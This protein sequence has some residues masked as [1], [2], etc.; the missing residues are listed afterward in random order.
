VL[1]PAIL[2]VVLLAGCFVGLAPE[3]SHPVTT[4]EGV[5]FTKSAPKV[6]RTSIEESTAEL[7]IIGEAQTSNGAKNRATTVS[8]QRERWREEVLAVFDRIVTK[9]RITYELI[10]KRE[11]HNGSDVPQ[12][13]NLLVGRT[14]VASLVEGAVVFTNASGGEVV[15]DERREL[16][17]RLAG[18]GK[19]DPFLDGIPDGVVVADQPAQGMKSGFLEMFESDDAGPDVGRV[20]V[21]FVGSRGHAQGRCGVFAFKIG[22][23]MAGEPRLDVDLSGDFLVRV[24]DGAPI[25]LDAHGPVRLVGREK[26]EGVDVSL[27]GSGEMKSALRITYL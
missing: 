10:D 21:R 7:R 12:E 2:S 20:D 18:F 4:R 23:Q 6:G 16:A 3:A 8:I 22:V 5:V 17:H 11:S 26:L 9:K 1:R 19:A 13:P 24:S 15:G 25:E 27:D 14:Y